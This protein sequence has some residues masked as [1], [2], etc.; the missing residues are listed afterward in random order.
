MDRRK[1]LGSLI[2]GVAAGAAVRSWP[3]KV[4]SFPEKVVIPVREYNLPFDFTETDLLL[5]IDEFAKRF[6]EPAIDN[7]AKDMAFN[8]WPY[9]EYERAFAA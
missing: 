7:L 3:F 1:F 5:S 2:G 4:F 9:H 8:L 6:M